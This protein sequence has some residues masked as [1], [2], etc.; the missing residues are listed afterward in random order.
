MQ[1][2]FSS[3]SRAAPDPFDTFLERHGYYRKHTARDPSCLFR[4]ISEQLYDTQNHHALVR[5]SCIAFMRKHW[6]YFQAA[7]PGDIELYLME[8]AKPKTFG[9]FLEL[10]AVSHIYKW[11]YFRFR[12]WFFGM[13]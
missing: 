3:G 7:I 4:A 1:R 6:R 10:Q 2:P 11:V 9:T 12:C 13:N 8:M 5:E